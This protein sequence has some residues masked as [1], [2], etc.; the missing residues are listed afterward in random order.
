MLSHNGLVHGMAKLVFAIA[1]VGLMA[2]GLALFKLSQNVR[3]YAQPGNLLNEPRHPVTDPMWRKAKAVA[4]KSAPNFTLKDSDGHDVTLMAESKKG[5]V[6]LVFT[7]D[8]CPCSIEAQPFFNQISEK[9]GDKVVFLGIIDGEKH[10]ASKYRDDF[11]V[12]YRMLLADD[13]AVFKSYDAT[14]SVYTTLVGSDGNVIK[15]WPGYNK[16]MLVELSELL[17]EQTK[18][19]PFQLDVSM[20]PAKM[21][22]GCAFVQ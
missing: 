9:F 5:P 6:V 18:V 1:V 20:A 15:Q 17:S 3:S 14:Q 21:N 16:A 13:G 12:P 11:K 2:C 10:I 8:G 4:G 22:S 7:K 19:G